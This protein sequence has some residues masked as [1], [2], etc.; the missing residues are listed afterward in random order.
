[1][2]R[3]FLKAIFSFFHTPPLPREELTGDPYKD[4]KI[5]G[6]REIHAAW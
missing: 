4:L 5:L 1:M 2:F 3:R 6:R